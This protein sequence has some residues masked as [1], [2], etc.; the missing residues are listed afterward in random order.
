MG[1]VVAVLG[2]TD[3]AGK[4]SNRAVKLLKSKGHTV[5]PVNPL[6]DIVDGDQC[7]KSLADCNE[8]I[9]T[10]TVYVNPE[11]GQTCL[12][13][14]ISAKPKRVILN[15]GT[16]NPQIA[17]SLKEAGIIV[18]EDCTLVMLNSNKF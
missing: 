17:K 8:E 3:Q 9:D 7:C 14:I 11:K 16:E 4:F 5:I 12:A 18:I 2:A 1:K 6:H 10:I 15:P 13:D